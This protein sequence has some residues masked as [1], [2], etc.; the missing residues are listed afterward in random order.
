MFA[1]TI[2]IIYS[3]LAEYGSLSKII[4][5]AEKGGRMNLDK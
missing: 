5:I 2:S 1:A 3:G 4:E